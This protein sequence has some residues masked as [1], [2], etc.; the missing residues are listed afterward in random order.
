MARWWLALLAAGSVHA[1]IIR[2][3]VVEQQTGKPLARAQVTLTPVAGTAG[4]AQSVR[5][6][7]YGTFEFA[8]MPGGSYL[9]TAGRRGFATVR[10]GQKHYKAEGV[11]IILDDAGSTNLRI[12]LP[13]MG[14]ISGTIVDENDVGLPE[15]DVVIY[16]NT[17]PPQI[18]ARGKTDDR[19]MFRIGGLEPGKYLVRTTGKQY[20]EGGYLPTFHKEAALVE[21]A[22]AID[23]DLDRETN[24]INVRPFMGRLYMVGGRVTARA[25]LRLVSDV[26]EE[27][28][29]ADG[30]GNFQFNPVAPG[31][32]EL[33]AE[34]QAERFTSAMAGYQ[35]LNVDRDLPDLRVGVNAL[36]YV[37]VSFEDQAH[38]PVDGRAL[39]VLARRK[40]LSGEGKPETLRLNGN[41]VSLPPGRWDFAME[42]NTAYY[43]A[44][45]SGPNPQSAMRMRADGWNETLLLAPAP[46]ASPVKFVLAAQPGAVHGIVTGPGHQPAAGAPVYLEQYDLEQRKRLNDV[47]STRTDTRGQYH[48]YGLVPGDYRLVSTFEF[49]VPDAEMIDGARPVSIRVDERQDL[50]EDLDLY[51][52]P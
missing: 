25:T 41:R 2:G 8:P 23:V 6:N 37:V 3:M 46:I 15:H 4:A 52:I 9:V 34:T 14:A 48:F 19:G 17:R 35:S 51:V 1:A 49:R 12:A 10:Y 13:R 20:E 43:P 42:P 40:D 18:A 16:R 29:L 50:S 39:Q 22:W 27:T 33:F 38:N 28:T 47:R 7:V 21:Q 44:S 31:Q 30:S 24:D 36:P 32:Y 11:P 45:F 5:T 26:G